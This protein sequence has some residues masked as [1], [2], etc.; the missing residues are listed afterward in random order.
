MGILRSVAT[1]V[2]AVCAVTVASVITITTLAASSASADPFRWAQVST[3]YHAACAVTTDGQGLCWGWNYQG[4][5]GTRDVSEKVLTPS[6]IVLPGNR[7]FASIS[8]GENFTT[9]GIDTDGAAWCWGQHHTG[10]YF[11]PTSNTP[12]RVEFPV[13]TRVTQLTNGWDIACAVDT[14]GSLWCWGDVGS[15]GN[16][17]TEATR[18]PERVPMPDGEAVTSVDAGPGTTC[19]VTAAHHLYCWGINDDGEAGIGYV[20]AKVA[21]PTAVR[22]PVDQVP[23]SVSVGLNRACALT[24][25]GTGWCWGDN[26]EGAF[27]DGTY[28][29]SATPQR[30]VTPNNESLSTLQTA[31]YHTC[32]TGSSGTT[33]C[34]GRG[35]FGELGTG[36]TLGGKTFRQPVLPVG[37]TL[38]ALATGLATTCAI[39]TTSRIW[40]WTGSDWGVAG[41]GDS[42]KSL[43]PRAIAP[44]GSPSVLAPSAASVRAETAAVTVAVNPNGASSSVSVQVDTDAT[45]PSP[46]T[47]AASGPA[48]AGYSWGSASASLTGLAPRT[49]YWVRA[50]ARNEFGTVTGA[51]T[52]F[53]TLGSEPVVSEPFVTSVGGTRATLSVTVDPGMLRTTS[54]LEWSASRDFTDASVISLA[55]I[56]GDNAQDLSASLSGLAPRTSYWVRVISTNRLGTT[57]SPRTSFTTLGRAPVVSGTT[58]TSTVSSVTVSASVDGGDIEGEAVAELSVDGS[59]GDTVESTTSSFAEGTNPHVTFRFSGLAPRT[60]YSVRVTARNAL[61][62]GTGSIVRVRTRGGLPVAGAPV[63]SGIETDR[64]VATVAVDPAGLATSVVLQTATD[65]SFTEDLDEHFVGILA[66]DGTTARSVLLTS[67]DRGT[68]YWVRTVATNVVGATTSAATRFTT[69]MPTGVVIN[70]DDE[71]TQDTEVTLTFTAP[72]NAVAVRVSD[73]PVMRGSRV[74][75]GTD[76]T[77]WSLPPSTDPSVERTV[78]VQFVDASGNYS[79]IYSDSILLETP[80][81]GEEDGGEDT[82]AP[83][84]SAARVTRVAASS[85]QSRGPKV[86]ITGRDSFSGIVSVQV[87]TGSRTVRHAVTATRSLSAAFTVPARGAVWVRLV[88]A[89]GNASKWRKV[90]GS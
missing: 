55:N 26:Y 74:F 89:A 43:F 19:A 11:S 14:A 90:R 80:D 33:W 13:D 50:V 17:S 63:V 41:T 72:R 1:R 21:L 57:S 35:G 31:W 32:A 58:A 25:A 34:W 40:C 69:L 49:T 36:T 8:A 29:D 62:S 82:I 87:R 27:G 81:T 77:A 2:A 9:C 48:G 59:F 78:Y 45:F 85:A 4:S 83:E 75:M 61:G 88:D 7:R 56:S 53:L 64:A 68:T 22:I 60:D 47:V 73:S 10:N 44:L 37:T 28:T 18:T 51:A 54:V 5:L 30:V 20:S 65:S 23:S 71:S 42:V 67:L 12:V 39:D 79:R 84:V 46:V 38:T 66:T 52:T 3:G 16:G 70:N 76:A 24:V 15:F 6:R 86:S